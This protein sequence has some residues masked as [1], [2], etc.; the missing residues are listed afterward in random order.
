MSLEHSPARQ[1]KPRVPPFVQPPNTPRP[2]R[3]LRLPEV[4]HR[5]G[6][7][8]SQWYE[9]VKNKT[10]PQPV[11]PLSGGR[12]VA[13]VESE[14]EAFIESRIAARDQKAAALQGTGGVAMTEGKEPQS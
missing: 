14:I 10:A 7:K 13:W 11:N 4:L 1:K 12:A 6:M 3:L 5:T 2:K 8:A 9:A